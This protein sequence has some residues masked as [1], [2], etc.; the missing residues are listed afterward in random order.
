MYAAMH[1]LFDRGSKIDYHAVRRRYISAGQ[2]V[3]VLAWNQRKE[4]ETVKQRAEAL[5]LGAGADAL[6]RK[7]LFSPAEWAPAL[8]DYLGTARGGGLAGVSTGLVDIHRL[9]LGLSKGW[10]YLHQTVGT[11]LGVYM[12][13]SSVGGMSTQST[14]IS[15]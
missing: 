12:A 4:L 2:Q 8:L 7:M 15:R 13:S 5:I 3:A 6:G 1:A 14:I 11:L 9:M 10:L